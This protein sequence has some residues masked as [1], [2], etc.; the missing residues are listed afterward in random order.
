MRRR[1]A[2]EIVMKLLEIP[3]RTL[4]EE[5]TR[6][7]GLRDSYPDPETKQS[8]FIT[9]ALIALDWVLVRVDSPSEFI[10]KS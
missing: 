1:H 4:E 8:A 10:E 2:E 6:L 9:G 5:V 7:R 3:I